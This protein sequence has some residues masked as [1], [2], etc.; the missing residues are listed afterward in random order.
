M[1]DCRFGSINKKALNNKK[2]INMDILNLWFVSDLI[3]EIIKII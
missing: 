2:F 3:K 1:C